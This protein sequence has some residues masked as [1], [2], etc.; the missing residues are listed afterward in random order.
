[1]ILN[2]YES[3]V[4]SDLAHLID[5]NYYDRKIEEKSHLRHY[6][7][8]IVQGFQLLED[9]GY[10]KSQQMKEQMFR[11]EDLINDMMGFN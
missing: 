11:D 9:H 8:T 10:D 3:R 4:G 5:S 6:I 2:Y 7:I 1:M